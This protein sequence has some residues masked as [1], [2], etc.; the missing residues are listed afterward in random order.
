MVINYSFTYTVWSKVS[1]CRNTVS[2]SSVCE[3]K[4]HKCWITNNYSNI[5]VLN[6]NLQDVQ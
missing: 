4:Q 1:V 5:V 3:I 6:I 2:V